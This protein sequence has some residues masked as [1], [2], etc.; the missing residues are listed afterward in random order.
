[1]HPLGHDRH[2]L[3]AVWIVALLAACTGSQPVRPPSSTIEA[4]GLIA[5]ARFY[6]DRVVYRLESGHVWEG[7]IG[8]FRSVMDWGAKLLVVGSDADGR[9][10]ATL[11]T[12]GG[13]PDTC[14]FTPEVGTDWGDGIAIGGVMW[15]K[16][17]GFSAD[18]T[19]TVGRDYPGGTRFCLNTRGEVSTVI[20]R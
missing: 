16:A 4:V 20:A 19:P 17:P 18:P 9:W 7:Q 13:L 8:S 11:G 10:V 12:Q 1:M 15:E 3:A 2:R 6:P 14:Y 5:D